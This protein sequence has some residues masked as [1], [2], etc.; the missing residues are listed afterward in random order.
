MFDAIVLA[1]GASRRLGGI[2]KTAEQIAG[3]PLLHRVVQAVAA[4]R[5]TA[6][7]GP[8]RELPRPVLWRRET[9]VGAGPV[10]AIAAGLS[11]TSAPTLL[12]LAADLPDIAPAVPP[13][14][15]A[16]DGGAQVA[17]LVDPDGHANYLAGAWRREALQHALRVVGDPAGA[18]VRALVAAA[19]DVTLVPD[20]GGWGRD[21]DTWD[22]LA[23]ARRRTDERR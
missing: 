13:L 23:A 15:D 10:A 3:V 21:C 20:A 14:L 8:R 19:G 17:L 5:R 12:V 9:P 18:P 2:D 6:V 11:A 7:V 4:A 22:D 16:I 1:G